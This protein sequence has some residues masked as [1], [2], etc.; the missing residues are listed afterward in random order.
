MKGTFVEPFNARPSYELGTAIVNPIDRV[1]ILLRDAADCPNGM[2]EFLAIRVTSYRLVSYD[3]PVE[4]M[5]VPPLV[6]LVPYR[7]GRA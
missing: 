7:K 2:N 3:C 4:F 5:S 6:G 1:E